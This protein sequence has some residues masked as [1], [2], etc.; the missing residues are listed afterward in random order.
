MVS[1]SAIA[2]MTT[3]FTLMDVVHGIRVGWRL[4]AH[5]CIENTDNPAH[6]AECIGALEWPGAV[7]VSMSRHFKAQ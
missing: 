3:T 4:A 5:K 1:W 6:A 2:V 7:R